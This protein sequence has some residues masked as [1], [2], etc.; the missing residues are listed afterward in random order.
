MFDDGSTKFVPSKFP[1]YIKEII[2][3]DDKESLMNLL[4]K[5]EGRN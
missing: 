2:A 4:E 5:Y 3:A 1:K